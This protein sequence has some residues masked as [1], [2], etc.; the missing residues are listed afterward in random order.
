MAKSLQ[1]LGRAFRSKRIGFVMYPEVGHIVPILKLAKWLV[2]AGSE[3]LVVALPDHRE[4]VERAGLEHVPLIPRAAPR[5]Y[6]AR[7]SMAHW[8]AHRA[9]GTVIPPGPPS[10]IE[11]FIASGRA[12]AL[13]H[14]MRLD[15]LCADALLWQF[16]LVAREVGVS[17]LILETDPIHRSG[18]FGLPDDEAVDRTPARARWLDERESASSHS[19]GPSPAGRAIARRYGYPVSPAEYPQE[20]RR[21]Q[22]PEIFLGPRC[23]DPSTG[24][25]RS[26]LGLGVDPTRAGEDGF[27]WDRL[28]E[29][30]IVYASLGNN[31]HHYHQPERLLARVAEAVAAL[32]RFQFVVHSGHHL[33]AQNLPTLPADAVVAPSVPQ[34]ALLRRASIFVTHGGFGGVKEAIHCGVPMLVFPMAFDQPVNATCVDRLRIGMVG[35]AETATASRIRRMLLALHRGPQRENLAALRA[36]IVAAREFQRGLDVIRDVMDGQR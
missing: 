33:T 17:T 6:F 30:P 29:R 11:E 1:T 32:P 9:G 34:L 31:T 2:A 16:S 25:R 18:R 19:R 21:C 22:I 26:C 24:P 23:L 13:V 15:L 7:W 20:P 14:R 27:P 12:E 5:G 4:M 3:V 8:A 10:L 28:D 36:R 35:N